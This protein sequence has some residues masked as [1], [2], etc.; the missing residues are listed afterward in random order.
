MVTGLLGSGGVC[1]G[2]CAVAPQQATEKS[3]ASAHRSVVLALFCLTPLLEEFVFN[4]SPS[5][6]AAG[7]GWQVATRS[8]IRR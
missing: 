4:P 3:N 8:P 2:V 6:P 5:S 7:L 1:G